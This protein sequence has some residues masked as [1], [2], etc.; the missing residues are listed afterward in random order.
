[1]KNRKHHPKLE[2]LGWLLTMCRF[3][4][5]CGI[6]FGISESS[7][8]LHFCVCMHIRECFFTQRMRRVCRAVKCHASSSKKREKGGKWW[9]GKQQEMWQ[10]RKDGWTEEQRKNSKRAIEI[11][12]MQHKATSKQLWPIEAS[13]L[14]AGSHRRS[15]QLV[16]CCFSFWHPY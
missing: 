12:K 15:G 11:D 1:M 16:C 6:I 10:E 3:P 4:Q 5:L 7:V 8:Y 14:T 13:K 9:T 2:L